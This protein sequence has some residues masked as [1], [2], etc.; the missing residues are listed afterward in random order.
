MFSFNWAL[1]F[2]VVYFFAYN[3]KIFK[4]FYF[5][6]EALDNFDYLQSVKFQL[7]FYKLQACFQLE[8]TL[9]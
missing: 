7:D 6:L 4:Q 5:Q 3:W 1:Y 2:I 9:L 8:N